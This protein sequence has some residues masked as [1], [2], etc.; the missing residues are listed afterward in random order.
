MVSSSPLF[1]P[2]SLTHSRGESG[3]GNWKLIIRDNVVNEYSGNFTDFHL[4]LWGEA[5]DA[6]KAVLLP[7]PSEA[8]D[9]NHGLP[10]PVPTTSASAATTSVSPLPTSTSIATQPTDHP[11]RPIKPKPSSTSTT[12]SPADALNTPAK[13]SVS[14][15]ST[16]TSSALP[17]ASAA[18]SSWLPGWLPSFGFGPKTTVWMYG[19][20]VLIVSFCV[21]L[22]IYFYWAR[23]QR[24][25]E[26]ARDNY[27]FDLIRDDEAAEG[28]TGGSGAAAGKM[29]Q[30]RAGELYDAF[31]AGSE[32]DDEGEFSEVEEGAYR[33][34][35][36]GAGSERWERVR[37]M[38]SEHHVIGGDS[39][40]DDEEAVDEKTGM[41]GT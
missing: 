13:P 6:S 33:D 17:S 8:D 34:R 11:D 20:A 3:I 7:M 18:P 40:S 5:I 36:Q 28:L 24:L 32:D 38:E 25:R 27:E 21:G 30:R 14:S 41:R 12:G 10:E 31:A 19:A 26:N 1:L 4:K 9:S 16:A 35:E 22:G 23:R 29:G 39:E 2:S 15:V 37:G